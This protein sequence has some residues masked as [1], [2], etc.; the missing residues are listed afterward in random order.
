VI[1]IINSFT[2]FTIYPNPAQEVLKIES[3]HH[4]ESVK[5][6]SLLGKLIKNEFNNS[7]DI[8]ELK[9]GLYFVQVTIDGKTVTKKFIKE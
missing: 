8:S 9:M 6:Y 5:I 2:N 7:I 3:Q 4:I 1:K